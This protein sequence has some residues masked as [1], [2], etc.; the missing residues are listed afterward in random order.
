MPTSGFSVI[1]F[2]TDFSARAQEEFAT[3]CALAGPGGRVI[4]AHV[5]GQSASPTASEE[6]LRAVHELF[7]AFHSDDP[8]VRLEHVV[9][10]GSLAEEIVALASEIG[11][12]L[13][14][15][16]TKFREGIDRLMVGSLAE[17]VLRRAGCA[18]LCLRPASPPPPRPKRATDI[19]A[20]LR[21][22]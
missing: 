15:L 2:P 10:T 21:I 11:C 17:A 18:V 22:D 3:A 13:I 7:G 19:G 20:F 4:V 5:I 6:R 8:K 14:V 16:G 1:L 12:D 9:R